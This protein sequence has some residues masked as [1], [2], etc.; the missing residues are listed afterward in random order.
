MGTSTYDSTPHRRIPVPHRWINRELIVAEPGNG[1]P[2]LL[3][4]TAARIWRL[5][6]DWAEPETVQQTLREDFADVDNEQ[7]AADIRA[8]LELMLRE[9]L[10][11]RGAL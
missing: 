11:E 9:G 1:V 5:L 6:E 8:A 10:I 2:M 3:N 4:P 7:L